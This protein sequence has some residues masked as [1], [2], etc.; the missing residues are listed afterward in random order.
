MTQPDAP[1]SVA[2]RVIE[3]PLTNLPSESGYYEACRR[4]RT[5]HELVERRIDELVGHTVIRSKT[6][7]AFVLNCL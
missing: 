7:L 5:E 2:S 4:R 3:I 1:R 6:Q